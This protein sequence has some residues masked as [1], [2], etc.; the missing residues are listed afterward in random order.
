MSDRPITSHYP[1]QMDP[2]YQCGRTIR[3]PHGERDDPDLSSRPCTTY[4]CKRSVHEGP[5]MSG[6]IHDAFENHSDSK[7]VRW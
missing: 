6:G 1:I 4:Y 5:G 3:L 7:P 2:R